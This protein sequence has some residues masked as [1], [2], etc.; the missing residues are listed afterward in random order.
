ML[1]H[2]SYH[3][4]YGRVTYLRPS[5]RPSL[6]L[7]IRSFA[8]PHVRPLVQRPHASDG[9]VTFPFARPTVCK[10]RLS[11]RPSVRPSVSP[12]TCTLVR[13][14][15][16]SPA[17]PSDTSSVRSFARTYTFRRH[18]S[19]RL[20]QQYFCQPRA[21]ECQHLR[22]KACYN[23]WPSPFCEFYNSFAQ[24]ARCPDDSL[25]YSTNNHINI[26]IILISF[27][28]SDYDVEK[29]IH[30]HRRHAVIIIA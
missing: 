24:N 22:L 21:Y 3:Q 25:P 1:I 19:K 6:R 27:H 7:Q 23:E 18:T 15:D 5:A 14:F 16:P 11:A 2:S 12:C 26:I 17:R 30:R 29:E 20:Q 4:S 8:R 13:S 9:R 28:R 10:S